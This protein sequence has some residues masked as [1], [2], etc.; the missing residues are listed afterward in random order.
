MRLISPPQLPIIILISLLFGAL[1]FSYSFLGL[2]DHRQVIRPLEVFH[3][4]TVQEIGGHFVFGFLVGLPSKNLSVALLTGL[5][6][7]TID[8]DHFLNLAGFH[9]QGRIDHSIPFVISSAIIIGMAAMDINNTKILHFDMNEMILSLGYRS[10]QK[11]EDNNKANSIFK[12]NIFMQFF[13][14]TVAAFL[15]HIAYDV[16]V[17]DNARF[18]IFAPFSFTQYLIPQ[19][20][21]LPIELIGMLMIYAYCTHLRQQHNYQAL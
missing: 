14:I 4:L 1:G 13:V 5:M 12:N 19:I 20:F 2:L 3:I 9:I 17:D 8:A 21:G 18:P 16:F 11:K 6:A 15:S 10:K 7:L